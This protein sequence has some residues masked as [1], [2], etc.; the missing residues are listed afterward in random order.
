[1]ERW[2]E[3]NQALE[4]SPFQEPRFG[5]SLKRQVRLKAGTKRRTSLPFAGAVAVLVICLLAAG[6]FLALP[7]FKSLNQ[8]E[9]ALEDPEWKVR[10]EYS[11]QGETLF[12]VFPDPGLSTGKNYGYRIRFTAPFEAFRDKTIAI[13]A[14]HLKSGTRLNVLPARTITEPTAGHSSLEG[15]TAEWD[16]PLSGKWKLEIEVEG[17]KYGDAVVTVADSPWTLSPTFDLPYTGNDGMA[18]H[19]VLAGEE[20]RLGLLVGPY[21]S[22]EGIQDRQPFAVGR[23]NKALW[24]FWGTDEELKGECRVVAVRMGDSLL[25]PQFSVGRLG[26]GVLGAD[27]TITSYLTFP[28]P[29]KWRVMVYVG[30]RLFGSLV[31]EATS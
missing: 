23:S 27:R 2:T 22:Q 10:S 6:V 24:Y 13:Q 30:D 4:K 8:E 29:G 12:T 5:E 18:H 17:A 21:A 25:T 1:M 26:G 15:F 20:G 31:V 9:L 7:L 19:Y 14:Y 11:V 16:L 28:K 3:W